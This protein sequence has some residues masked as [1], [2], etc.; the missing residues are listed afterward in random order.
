M[1]QEHLKPQLA[2]KNKLYFHCSDNLKY[3]KSVK[4]S[5]LQWRHIEGHL[6]FP[7]KNH[8][9]ERKVTEHNLFGW[10]EVQS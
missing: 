5:N 6:Q 1:I 9:M 4:A 7:T 3:M 8:I 10:K 2:C